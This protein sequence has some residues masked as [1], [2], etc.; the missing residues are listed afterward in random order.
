[1]RPKSQVTDTLPREGP[2]S[3]RYEL[4]L[5]FKVRAVLH[6]PTNIEG[7]NLAQG[8]VGFFLTASQFCLV[9]KWRH[10][11]YQMWLQNEAVPL[12]IFR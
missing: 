7:K 3:P 9:H 1:M 10:L 11:V 6:K 12:V 2:S 4:F 8:G 5:H